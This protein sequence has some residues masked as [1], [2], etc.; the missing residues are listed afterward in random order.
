MNPGDRIQNYR[1]IRLVFGGDGVEI[2]EAEHESLN[3]RMALKVLTGEFGR[4]PEERQALKEELLRGRELAHPNIIRVY[5]FVEDG[6][7][8]AIS[9]EFFE[10]QSLADRL[11]PNAVDV[12]ALAPIATQIC[13]ALLHVHQAGLVHGDLRP[14]TILLGDCGSVKLAEFGVAHSVEVTTVKIGETRLVDSGVSDYWSPQVRHGSMHTEADDIYALGATLRRLLCGEAA[15]DE[16]EEPATSVN[17]TRERRNLPRVAQEWDAALAAC[18]EEEPENRPTTV[19]DLADR[20][21]LSVAPSIVEPARDSGGIGMSRQAVLW[22][23]GLLGGIVLLAGVYGLGRRHAPE[24]NV[25]PPVEQS[26]AA[27]RA[28]AQGLQPPVPTL[29]EAPA[30]VPPTSAF[31]NSLG[32]PFVPVGDLLVC[33]F[34]TRVRDYAAFVEATD[35]ETRAGSSYGADGWSRGGA[36]WREASFQR[37]DDHPVTCVDWFDA[38]AFCAWLTELERGQGLLNERQAYRLPTAE[39]WAG[40]ATIER[41]PWVWSWGFFWPPPDGEAN[42]AGA[43]VIDA[44]W[45]SDRKVVPDYR[46]PWRRTAPVDSGK[47]HANGLM[48]LSGNVWEWTSDFGPD[49]PTKRLSRGGSWQNNHPLNFIIDFENANPVGSRSENLGFRCVLAEREVA[50][51][52]VAGR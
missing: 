1:L 45:P 44:E 29:P 25:Q 39:E 6:D 47:P 49:S 9:M 32:M 48:H 20:L 7:L 3:E 17:E 15:A 27:Q 21:G 10:S 16:E 50:D 2:W 8:A 37:T 51:P 14:E 43:E 31:T 13:S 24:P 35:A 42:L 52:A 11:L 41:E 23:A 40:F 22:L 12:G 26:G 33:R 30:L 4:A 18:L 36:T 34:E 28:P 46:D 19:V 5:E 38:G